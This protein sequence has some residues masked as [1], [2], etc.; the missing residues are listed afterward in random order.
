MGKVICVTG[1]KLRIREKVIR[2]ETRV[3]DAVTRRKNTASDGKVKEMQAAKPVDLDDGFPVSMACEKGKF[4][5]G[6]RNSTRQRVEVSWL[7]LE[8]RT[9]DPESLVVGDARS[10]DE[11]HG[12]MYCILFR[13]T[14]P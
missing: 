3:N 1:R 4:G 9:R 6:G 10:R 11:W 5:M 14:R 7:A 2:K 13:R 12:W 8:C